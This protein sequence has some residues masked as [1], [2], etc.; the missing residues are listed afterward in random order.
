MFISAVR[1][2]LGTQS[3]AELVESVRYFI[4]SCVEDACNGSKIISANGK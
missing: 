4:Y 3:N 2:L 1:C